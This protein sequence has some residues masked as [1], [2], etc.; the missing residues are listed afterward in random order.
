MN[1][2]KLHVS[3]CGFLI[4]L[5][6]VSCAPALAQHA[7]G[8]SLGGTFNTPAGATITKTIMDRI[9]RRN[10]E[11]RLAARRSG[12]NSTGRTSSSDSAQPVA[13]LNEASV[14]FARQARSSKRA[15]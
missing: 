5:A 12:A 3:R 1:K 15:K 8:E 2:S 4:L 13:K 7:R 14:L 11:R 10:R 6:L 9:A